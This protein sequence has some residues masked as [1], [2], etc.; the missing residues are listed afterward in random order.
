[1]N[2]KIIDGYVTIDGTL[3]VSASYKL[4]TKEGIN[5]CMPKEKQPAPSD[6]CGNPNGKIATSGDVNR[7]VV[8]LLESLA[9]RFDD[10]DSKCAATLFRAEK[11]NWK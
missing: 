4:F 6:R 2:I 8:R 1:M 11:E 3:K 5:I 7:T 10:Y 9:K